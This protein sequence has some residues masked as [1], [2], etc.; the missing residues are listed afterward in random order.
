MGRDS[1]AAAEGAGVRARAVLAQA[2]R[3]Q[4]TVTEGGLL[5]R[6]RFALRRLLVSLDL[7]GVPLV[8]TAPATHLAT[9]LGHA[10]VTREDPAGRGR[11][12][13]CGATGH[14]AGPP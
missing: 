2:A 1:K 6:V 11:R 7:P 10:R 3:P 13:G 5:R 9:A 4:A 8:G 12:G 14:P